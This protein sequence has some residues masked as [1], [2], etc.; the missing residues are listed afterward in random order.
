MSDRNASA[1]SARRLQ[2]VHASLALSG[3]T[4]LDLLSQQFEPEIYYPLNGFTDVRSH[5]HFFYH[6]HEQG[7]AVPAGGHFHTF[8]G[9]A[10][11][12]SEFRPV[13]FPEI[14]L[15]PLARGETEPVAAG[16]RFPGV[17][18][19]LVGIDI[20]PQGVPERLFTTNRWVTG[21]TW[22][23]GHQ[24]AQM[25]PLFQFPSYVGGPEVEVAHWLSHVMRVLTPMARALLEERDVKL[26]EWRRRRTRK[27][28]VLDDRR[29]EVLS[30]RR[31]DF[32]TLL[33]EALA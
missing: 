8:I 26:A 9:R 29:V 30:E 5:A 14:A 21:E 24:V 17:Y 12:P 4:I 32:A 22:F 23:A 31:F 33:A 6:A 13:L 11:M 28:H 7:G 1:I 10:A 19:H 25:L 27:I 20:G 16:P 2:D 18:S 15:A 3:S